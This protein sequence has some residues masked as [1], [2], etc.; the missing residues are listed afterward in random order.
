M[1]FLP[2]ISSRGFYI[3][4]GNNLLDFQIIEPCCAK[5][6]DLPQLKYI[7]SCPL[8]VVSL[9]SEGLVLLD[10]MTCTSLS[11]SRPAD[12]CSN[13]VSLWTVP[14]LSPFRLQILV[15]LFQSTRAIQPTGPPLNPL[16]KGI[17][18]RS[19]A[20]CVS[21]VTFIAFPLK[22]RVLCSDPFLELCLYF[23]MHMCYEKH[24]CLLR[25]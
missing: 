5:S 3:Y 9:P 8:E 11:S 16:Y 18:L 22:L 2:V 1:C 23:R 15:I 17:Y 7:A 12:F 10:C 6:P 21:L 19:R 13:L 14:S 20:P 25:F 24:I 4:L